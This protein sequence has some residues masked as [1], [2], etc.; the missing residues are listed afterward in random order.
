MSERAE[1]FDLEGAALKRT[2]F[3]EIKLIEPSKGIW[4]AHRIQVENGKS[5]RFTR[6]EFNQVR[7]QVTV[8]DSVFTQQNLARVP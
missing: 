6:L 7:T 5:R 1:A 3:S 2:D 8:S 4:M